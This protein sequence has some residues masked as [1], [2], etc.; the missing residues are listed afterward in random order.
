MGMKVTEDGAGVS[1]PPSLFGFSDGHR[2]QRTLW[3]G[4]EMRLRYH[5]CMRN[6]QLHPPPAPNPLITPSLPP[7]SRP[8]STDRLQNDPS[9]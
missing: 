3:S 8:P 9:A 4:M 5:S 7:A 2:A 1:Y 6:N